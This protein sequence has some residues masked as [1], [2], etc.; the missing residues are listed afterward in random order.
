MDVSFSKTVGIVS[1]SIFFHA[2]FLWSFE[3]VAPIYQEKVFLRPKEILPKKSDKLEFE[4]IEVPPQKLI[5]RKPIPGK[6][7]SE[8]D[9]LNQDLSKK[10]SK[11]NQ[12]P[13]AARI[14]NADQLA[15][16]RGSRTVARHSEV[17]KAT[18]ESHHNDDGILRR[19]PKEQRTPQDDEKPNPAKPSGGKIMTQEVARSKSGG[20]TLYGMVSFE[21]TG[22]GMG[23]YMKRLKE[24]VW[25]AWFPYLSFK[26]PLDARGASAVVSFVLDANGEIKRMQ[27]LQSDGSGVFAS[28]CLEAVRK[29]AGFGPLPKEI[30]ALLGKDELEIKFGFNYR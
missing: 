17:A 3:T 19:S 2:A 12:P 27:L 30:L 11:S 8:R 4:Y 26:Y 6:K 14:G 15:Q 21:A 24:R 13:A 25:L 16:K 23:E 20:A 7:I 29:A 9:A 28:Y 10:Q 18:E 22:S 5:Q 1:L